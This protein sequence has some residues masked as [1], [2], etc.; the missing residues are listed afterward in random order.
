MR[1]EGG[2]KNSA[3][4]RVISGFILLVFVCFIFVST[5]LATEQSNSPTI[6]TEKLA[7]RSVFPFQSS[8][9]FFVSQN[10]IEGEP[11]FLVTASHSLREADPTSQGYKSYG[12]RK[13]NISLTNDNVL[14]ASF[15]GGEQNARI[16]LDIPVFDVTVIEVDLKKLGLEGKI[17]PLKIPVEL[18]AKFFNTEK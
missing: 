11:V 18:K 14:K 15:L 13:L 6:S 2:N 5:A 10:G 16:V 4:G 3:L 7:N 1:I 17:K 12:T 9:A 8:S